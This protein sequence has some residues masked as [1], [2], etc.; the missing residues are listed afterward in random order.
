MNEKL[1][2]EVLKLQ[3]SVNRLEND[4]NLLINAYKTIETNSKMGVGRS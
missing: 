4:N 2:D 3:E 1:K